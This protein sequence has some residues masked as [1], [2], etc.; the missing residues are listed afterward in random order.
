LKK[1]HPLNSSGWACYLQQ[2]NEDCDGSTCSIMSTSK[3]IAT[4]L[5]CKSSIIKQ[6]YIANLCK[7]TIIKQP[8]VCPTKRQ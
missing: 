3:Y 8:K 1:Y 2:A 6:P 5:L 7:S 4:L